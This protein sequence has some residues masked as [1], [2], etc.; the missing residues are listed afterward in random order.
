MHHLLIGNSIASIS[1]AEEIR[2]ADAGCAI[3]ILSDEP[4]KPY[5]RPLI[6]YY[7]SGKIEKE[8][9]FT[10][11]ANLYEDLSIEPLLGRK[12]V[13][14]ALEEQEVLLEDKQRIKFDRLLIASGGS[15]FVPDV[16]GEHLDGVFTFTTLDDVLAIDNF[17]AKNSPEAAL[18]L[19]GGMIGLKAAEALAIRGLSV[20]IV[21]LADRLLAVTFDR[22]ASSLFEHTLAWHGVKLF[23]NTTIKT[24]E[25]K[26]GRVTGCLLENSESI[27]CQMVVLAVG[28]RPRLELAAGAGLSTG[29]GIAVD[30]HMR[31]SHPAIYAAGDVAQVKN[32]LDETEQPV[33]IWPVAAVTGRVAGANMA[34]A[35][36]TFEGAFPANSTTL[37]ERAAIA[38]GITEPPDDGNFKTA[39]RSQNKHCYRKVVLR[40]GKLAGFIMVDR[41]ERAGIYT[42]LLRASVK[43]DSLEPEVLLSDDFGLIWLPED[44]RRDLIEK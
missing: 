3:T 37:F 41:I 18:V 29:R 43:L 26:K 13:E 20:T 4:H 33:P 5:S 35:D 25:G 38:A 31:T 36:R 30:E 22:E 6:S 23:K 17:I 10:F 32:I 28:V 19:G 12:A 34:G 27:P 9:L 15:P 16:H 44:Y 8:R 11:P 1:A 24:I 42:G 40:G 39:I 7:L 21:E 14:I 2:K